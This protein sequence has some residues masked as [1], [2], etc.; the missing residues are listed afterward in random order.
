MPMEITD[1]L[2]HG[3]ANA[4]PLRD[5]EGITGLDGR[6]VRAM[7]SAERRAGAAILS[8]NVTGYYLP[9]NEEEKARFVRSMRHRAKEILCAAELYREEITRAKKKDRIRRLKEKLLELPAADV[10]T[11][12]KNILSES[13]GIIVPVSEKTEAVIRAENIILKA[14]LE[15]EV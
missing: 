10:G 8:D 13:M 15:M 9:A 6:T 11:A 1:L 12:Y 14:T 5:L 3:Q 4:V 7:I 2:S